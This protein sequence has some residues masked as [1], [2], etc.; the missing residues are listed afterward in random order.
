M[1][2]LMEAVGKNFSA[3]LS[4]FFVIAGTFLGWFLN[5]LTI[6]YQDQ[7]RLVF[8]AVG[9]P[10]DELIEV[11]LRTKTSPSEWSIRICNIGKTACF[12]EKFYIVRKG[13]T[14]VECYDVC[15]DYN[16]IA[17]SNSILYTL[18]QQDADALQNNYSEHY[19][20]PNQLY[21][22]IMRLLGNIPVIRNCI[23]EPLFRQG[24]CEVIAYT[25]NGKKIHGKI[26]L[27]L[28]YIRHTVTAT[29]SIVE[30]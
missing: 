20:S 2:Q 29:D 24:E 6:M 18:M 19:K 9:T 22:R 13:Y 21:L 15:S 5:Q 8:A 26:D 12:L 27:P 28:L 4:G 1:E 11:E 10:N 23:V 17:P 14:L 16:S 7:P 3:I 25:I 30:V